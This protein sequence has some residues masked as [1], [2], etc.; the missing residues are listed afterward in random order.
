[1]DSRKPSKRMG[2]DK[3]LY[4]LDI[5]GD[6]YSA[7]MAVVNYICFAALC[8]CCVIVYV[9]GVIG[10]FDRYYKHLAVG[11]IIAIVLLFVIHY[12]LLD[13]FG[14]PLL[15]P[16]IGTIYFTEFMHIIQYIATFAVVILGATIFIT[17][18]LSKLDHF[19]G[20]AFTSALLFLIVIIILHYYI[21]DN[22]G[23]PLIFPPTLW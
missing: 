16:P 23:V 21:N 3:V 15:V 17:A 4:L 8:G 6:V 5:A 7:T 10:Q 18:L 11:G 13:N 22:F 19:Y 2:V 12:I 20:H 9:S 14:I 1:M